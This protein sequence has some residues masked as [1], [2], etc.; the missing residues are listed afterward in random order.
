M[1]EKEETLV[2]QGDKVVTRGVCSGTH[3]GEFNGIPATG[4]HVEVPWMDMWRAQNG[5]FVENWVR[6]DM[7]AMSAQ[8]G[9]VP[10]PKA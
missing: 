1:L 8:L 9:V 4:K 3:K 10:P 5:K 2:V 6:L 7:L